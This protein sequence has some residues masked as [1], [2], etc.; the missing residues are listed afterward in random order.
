[1]VFM[2]SAPPRPLSRLARYQ[3]RTLVWGGLLLLGLMVAAMAGHSLWRSHG[4]ALARAEMQSQN[5]AS[6]TEAYVAAHIGALDNSVSRVVDE[7]EQQL[8]RQGRLDPRDAEGA[9]QRELARRTD[10]DGLYVLDVGGRLVLG[11]LGSESGD[12]AEPAFGRTGLDHARGEL[13][14]GHPLRNPITGTWVLP[15]SRHFHHPDGQSAGVVLATVPVSYLSLLLSRVDSGPAGTV[16]LRSADNLRQIVRYPALAGDAGRPGADNATPELRAQANDPAWRQATY[17]AERTP[18][19]VTRI[20]TVR[21][22]RLG[23]LLLV[24]GL[25]DAD[26]LQGWQAES[27]TTLGLSLAF[28]L[29]WGLGGMLLTRALERSREDRRRMR[30]LAQVFEH[31]GEAIIITDAHN[32][33]VEVN[34]AF[35]AQSGYAPEEVVGRN[36]RL[37]ASGHT[38]PEDYTRIWNQLQATGHWRGELIDR[39]RDGQLSPK[40]MSISLV[41]DEQ[42]Q[43]THHI[44]HAIDLREIKAAEQRILHLAHHDHLTGLPNR[45]LLRARLDQAMAQARRDQGRLAM[46]FIDLDRFKDI[47][48]SLGHHIGD[49]L[50]VEVAQRLR[51]VVRGNDIVA[52][53]GGDEFVLVLAGLEEGDGGASAAA[54]VAG[55]VLQA[56]RQPI[57]VEGHELHTGA[58]IGIT[59]FP[60]DGEDI[61]ALMKGADAAMYH[62]KGAGR[63][64]YH[65][66]TPAMNLASQERLAMEQGL[67]TAIERGELFLQYQPQV[68]VA[69]LETDAVEAL[70]RWRH[71]TLGLVSPARFIPVAEETGQIAAIGRWVLDEAL[72]QLALWRGAGLTGLRVAVNVSAQQL[73]DDQFAPTV[74]AALLRHGVPGA[75]LELEVTESTAMRDPLRTAVQLQQL[76]QLGVSLAIDDFGTGYSSLAYLK[77]LPLNHLKLDRSFVMDIERDPNDAAICAA[78]ITLAH[79]L[80]LTVVAEGVETL[81]QLDYLRDLHCDLVQG[82]LFSRPLDAAD[83]PAFLERQLVPAA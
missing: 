58:S 21:R 47:N 63:G 34:P 32:Q 57:R 77:Q 2:S 11:G 15:M 74:A 48:D 29:V 73:R 66:Y 37:L 33:I 17:R 82:Y 60:Q 41:R 40:W 81:A 54:T 76:R 9:L 24:V 72:A 6:L 27:R 59:L 65:F 83:L 35:V 39:Q 19:G 67:R 8:T 7:L 18:D 10:L 80:G 1:M 36:P 31:S 30:L 61:D 62:A 79:A 56:L 20:Y 22:M 75:A 68:A 43:V 71:P 28:M 45:V 26:Y 3:P 42:G 78:T 4:Q 55:K 69:G 16:V 52:R 64:G 51:Q 49:A 50:L 25:A 23:T 14:V 38:S 12:T 5:L 44:A 13:T 53:L 46:L 70:L